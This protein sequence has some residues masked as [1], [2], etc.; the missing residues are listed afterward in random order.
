MSEQMSEFRKNDWNHPPQIHRYTYEVLFY[1]W[2]CARLCFMTGG[3]SWGPQSNVN[4][5]SY[6]HCHRKWAWWF[7]VAFPQPAFMRQGAR[8]VPPVG[9]N[10]KSSFL[11]NHF[12]SL[13]TLK[14][15][16]IF[17]DW[18][19]S[20]SFTFFSYTLKTSGFISSAKLTIFNSFSVK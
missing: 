18:G 2:A 12:I 10:K 3:G 11:L 5:R 14:S 16:L 4:N 15:H 1:V 6:D 20:L 7:L 17:A 19:S 8:V 9:E 13:N